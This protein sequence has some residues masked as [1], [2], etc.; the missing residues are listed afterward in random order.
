M[1]MKKD[2]TR[3][4]FNNDKQTYAVLGS[5]KFSGSINTN[6]AITITVIKYVKK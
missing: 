5:S 6:V 4:K 1:P 3:S 2:G